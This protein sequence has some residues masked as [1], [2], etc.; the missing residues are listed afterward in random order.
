M[1]NAA[2]LC[3]APLENG[4][5]ELYQLPVPASILSGE[6][7]TIKTQVERKSM[8]DSG[9]AI[10]KPASA[11]RCLASLGGRTLKRTWT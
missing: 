1:Q 6:G 8:E 2:E 9:E 7:E 10:Q 4:S 3:P 11:V 5:N